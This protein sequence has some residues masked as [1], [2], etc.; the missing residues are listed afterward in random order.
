MEAN[1]PARDNPRELTSYK[2]ILIALV[3]KHYGYDPNDEKS[4]VTHHIRS[5]LA[6]VGLS[7]GDDTIRKCLKSSARLL[8]KR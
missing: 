5:R 6:D 3:I 2:K 4:P 8:D 7:L 1:P